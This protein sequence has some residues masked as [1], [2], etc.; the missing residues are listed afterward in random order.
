MARQTARESPER[1]LDQSTKVVPPEAD[2]TDHLDQGNSGDLAGFEVMWANTEGSQLKA[3]TYL[4]D[5]TLLLLPR[6]L[7]VDFLIR[8]RIITIYLV[9]GG[10]LSN[11]VLQGERFQSCT[12]RH[13]GK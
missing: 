8:L 3:T 13:L 11:I 9:L 10:Y 4:A 6:L 7:I 5:E 12:A 2:G 1:A